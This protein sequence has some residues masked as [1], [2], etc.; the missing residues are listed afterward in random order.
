MSFGAPYMLFTLLA[1]P[2]LAGFVWWA[3]R[4]RAAAIRRIGEPNL[5]ALLSAAANGPMRRIR[6]ALWFVGVVLLIVALARPQWGSDIEIVETRGLQIMIVLDVSRSMLAADIEPT[7]LDRAKLE[8][9]DLISR[10]DGDAVGITLFSG[11]SFVQLPLTTD[12][13]TARAYL[14]N[15]RPR[16]I[17]RQGT[18]IGEAIG[19]AMIGF[20]DKRESQKVIVIMS[21]GEIYDHEEKDAR[22]PIEAAH[23]AAGD[24]TIIYTVGF[25]SPDGAP[26]L[27]RDEQGNVIGRHQGPDGNPVV[28]RLDESLLQQI[29]EAG[30]GRYY[31]VGEGGGVAAIADEIETFQ[32]EVF[33]SEFSQRRV[34]R[35]QL[36][37]LL[38]ALSLFLAEILTDRLYL[39][40]RQGLRRTSGESSDA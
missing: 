36:F 11:A 22:D 28:S 30:G 13:A 1:V 20:S 21:D 26:V 4:R 3:F 19:T 27:M 34:E 6:L 7:R 10:L 15:A 31:R 14:H 5:V 12:Y 32:D 16:S 25:G 29:A 8:A 18:V 39:S 24:G 2:A 35:F 37:L 33:R 9:T 40:L 23:E 17:T 38:G